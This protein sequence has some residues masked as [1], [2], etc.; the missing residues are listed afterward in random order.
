[1]NYK[2]IKYLVI[3][4]TTLLII[5]SCSKDELRD[6]INFVND[7]T[8]IGIETSDYDLGIK[9][10]APKNW[11]LQPA[12]LSR[13]V[14]SNSNDSFIY[15]PIYLFFDT[16]TKSILSVGKVVSL[17]TSMSKNSRINF[18]KSLLTRKNKN[19]KLAF[20]SF[21]NNK[22]HFNKISYEKENLIS[23]KIIFNND[24][25]DIIQ[26]DYSFSKENLKSEIEFIKASIGTIDRIK[27]EN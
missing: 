9:F 16:S 18:Y 13:K 25:F 6:E 21:T 14:E 4:L 24:N 27:K 2:G 19:N 3:S 15:Q 17:D 10:N 11:D 5:F 23:Y 1:M 22:I 26:F 7:S 20:S 8:K 12:S